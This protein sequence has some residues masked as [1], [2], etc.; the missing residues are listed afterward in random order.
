MTTKV[1]VA[2]HIAYG[3]VTTRVFKTEFEVNKWRIA[4]ARAWW[5]ERLPGRRQSPNP[6]TLADVFWDKAPGECFEVVEA[7]Q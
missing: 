2:T 1:L 4:I 5:T 7:E 3:E 6:E